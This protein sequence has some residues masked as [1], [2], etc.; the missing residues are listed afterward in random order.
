M[1]LIDFPATVEDMTGIVPG[2]THFGRSL[3]PII[4]GEKAVH[5][6]AVFC[7]GG[8]LYDE[9]YASCTNHLYT[10]PPLPVNI[11]EDKRD[12]YYWPCLYLDAGDGPQNTKAVMCRTHDYKY[13]KR[14]YEKDE[15]Y[16]LKADPEELYNKIDDPKMKDV[17]AGLKERLTTFY[18]ETCDVVPQKRDS[19]VFKSAAA[20]I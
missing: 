8:R 2:H 14:L 15:L 11:P 3:T 12:G 13:V 19:R 10:H 1:E 5:R 6:D 17:L 4:R 7:E 20:C 9:Q 16:D 18:L